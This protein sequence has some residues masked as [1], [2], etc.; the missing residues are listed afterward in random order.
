MTDSPGEGSASCWGSAPGGGDADDPVCEDVECDDDCE[1]EDEDH[2]CDC[3]ADD[4]GPDDD[5]H[6]CD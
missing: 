5:D 2:D 6:Q 4:R 3:E 1:L